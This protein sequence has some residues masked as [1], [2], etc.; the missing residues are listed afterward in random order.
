MTTPTTPQSLPVIGWREWLSL[1]DLGIPAIKAKID[2]GARTSALHT[3]DYDIFQRDGE[4]W[5]TFHLH[6]LKRSSTE[7]TCTTKVVDYRTVSDSGGHTERRPF[8]HTTAR[9]GPHAW[10]VTLSL[11]NRESML[12]R[13]LLGR[14]A[15]ESQFL[16]DVSTSYLVGQRPEKR[17]RHRPPSSPSH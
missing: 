7:Y 13:M 4:D 2:T 3:H 9:I 10:D 1:P 6:P 12:F 14:T 16:V 8:I 11:T 17:H 5:V 15:L